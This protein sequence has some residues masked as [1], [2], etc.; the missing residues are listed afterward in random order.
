MGERPDAGSHAHRTGSPQGD[1]F[2][3]GCAADAVK[4][5]ASRD[6]CRTGPILCASWWR[7]PRHAE[8]RCVSAVGR[9]R[10]GVVSTGLFGD[11]ANCMCVAPSHIAGKAGA[12]VK[13]DRRDAVML[14]KLDRAGEPTPVRV[15]ATTQ[16]AVLCGD[17]LQ[18]CQGV[19]CKRGDT[20]P[21]GANPSAVTWRAMEVR[22]RHGHAFLAVPCPTSCR[23][24]P[25]IIRGLTRMGALS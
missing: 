16:P 18:Q 22:G 5:S 20:R 12:R 3:G 25:Q 17:V 7:G 11:G 19:T 6:P 1:V 8:A 14:A 10:A 23:G 9:G 24:S 15:P 13:T 4:R 2:Y 21:V